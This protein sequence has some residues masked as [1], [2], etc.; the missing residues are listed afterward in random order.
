MVIDGGDVAM[1]APGIWSAGHFV[2]QFGSALPAR[3]ET[4]TGLSALYP[5]LLSGSLA[6]LRGEAELIVGH[7]PVLAAQTAPD[8][9]ERGLD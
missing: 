8:L 5:F 6:L 2:E 3:S 7:L 4:A 1:G 9:R